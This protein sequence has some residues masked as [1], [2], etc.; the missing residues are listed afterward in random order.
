MRLFGESRVLQRNARQR[1]HADSAMKTSV[2]EV[3]AVRAQ[4]RADLLAG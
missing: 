1:D 4:P 3:V 2:I